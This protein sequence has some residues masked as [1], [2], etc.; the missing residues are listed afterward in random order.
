MDGRSLKVGRVGERFEPV[1][2]I[3]LLKPF[4]VKF[5]NKGIA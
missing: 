1:K 2:P 4:L 5:L 3:E